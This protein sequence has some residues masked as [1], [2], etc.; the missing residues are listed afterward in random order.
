M[1]VVPGGS[2]N[3]GI[4]GTLFLCVWIV[5]VLCDFGREAECPQAL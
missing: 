4:I 5:S 2:H 3:L 1:R